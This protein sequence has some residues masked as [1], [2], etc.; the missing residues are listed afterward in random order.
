MMLDGLLYPLRLPERALDALGRIV[1][2]LGGLRDGL[3]GSLE[4]LE[5]TTDDVLA[6]LRP[7]RTDTSVVRES[8]SR[9]PEGVAKLEHAVTGL[10]GK[11]EHVQDGVSTL[12]ADMAELCAHVEGLA[13]Q[14]DGLQQITNTIQ[15]QVDEVT[16]DLP[17]ASGTGAIAK[18]REAVG[19]GS[20]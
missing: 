15:G 14:L 11:L 3:T 17:G 1:E 18:V 7:L 4:R 13:R 8:T 16:R 9:L 2:D 20:S 12:H 19:R 6:E 10:G 5:R